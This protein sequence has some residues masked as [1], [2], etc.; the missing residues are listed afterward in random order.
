MTNKCLERLAVLLILKHKLLITNMRKYLKY[1]LKN[2]CS[3]V[4]FKIM[5]WELLS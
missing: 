5:N 1:K 2:I 3:N 4:F